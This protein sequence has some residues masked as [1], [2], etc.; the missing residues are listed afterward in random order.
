MVFKMLAR[1]S[2]CIAVFMTLAHASS[3]PYAGE[4]NT[5][6]PFAGLAQPQI[7]QLNPS[8]LE[9]PP[10]AGQKTSSGA[11]SSISL[12]LSTPIICV[13][14][15]AFLTHLCCLSAQPLCH[16]VVPVSRCL[17]TTRPSLA[18]MHFDSL[19]LTRSFRLQGV[20]VRPAAAPPLMMD[21]TAIG[22]TPRTTAANT[23][24]CTG[25]MTI[26]YT[27][28]QQISRNSGTSLQ[29]SVPCSREFHLNKHCCT[30]LVR[31]VPLYNAECASLQC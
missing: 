28:T 25:T 18:R 13:C 12:P 1:L 4:Q 9:A 6:C 17:H 16:A 26:A 23:L 20:S 11:Q 24:S 22:A 8:H 15:C 14:M 5:G 3:C 29:I 21:L 31:N 2:F 30:D 10:D 27:Q 7:E 19:S